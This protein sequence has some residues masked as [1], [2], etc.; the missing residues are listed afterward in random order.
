MATQRFFQDMDLRP[1][2][3]ETLIDSTY[4]TEM[5]G[6]WGMVN[7]KMGGPFVSVSFVD[8]SG[9]RVI[10]IEGYCHA[11]QFDKREFLRYIDAIVHSAKLSD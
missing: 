10:A 7:A 4:A 8:P 6:L 2:L 11:P 5:R 9:T 3:R 1:T